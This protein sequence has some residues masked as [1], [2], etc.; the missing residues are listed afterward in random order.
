MPTSAGRDWLP[1]SSVLKTVLAQEACELW[2]SRLSNCILPMTQVLNVSFWISSGCTAIEML[3]VTV[4]SG[5]VN[6]RWIWPFLGWLRILCKHFSSSQVRRS[7]P[8]Y[9]SFTAAG[10]QR[11]SKLC[12]S[13]S[14]SSWTPGKPRE[15]YSENNMLPLF[16]LQEGR[17]RSYYFIFYSQHIAALS[18]PKYQLKGMCFLFF[19][20]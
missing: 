11:L 7:L 10:S 20:F 8:L 4:H 1:P 6:Q 14:N 17:W 13:C 2:P 3:S 5:S 15:V 19:F 12:F 18:H 9:S 16:K